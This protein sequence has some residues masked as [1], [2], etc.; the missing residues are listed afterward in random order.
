[1]R[2]GTFG[3]NDLAPS[4]GTPFG[5]Y[6]HSGIGREAGQEAFDAYLEDKSIGLPEGFLPDGT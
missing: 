4:F 2:T 3:I 5:G 6:K 1:V